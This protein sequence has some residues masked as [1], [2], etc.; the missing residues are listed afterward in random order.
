MNRRAIALHGL[1]LFCLAIALPSCA[2]KKEVK[3]E[4]SREV[5]V[6]KP[7]IRDISVAPSGRLDTSA[8]ERVV[9][10]KMT[11]DDNLQATFDVDGRFS[12]RT[13]Q[14][15]QPGE[16][17]GTFDVKQGETGWVSVTGHLL[18][19][20][21]GAHQD[22]RRERVLEL[23]APPPPPPSVCDAETAARYDIDLSALPILFHFNEFHVTD[24]ARTLLTNVVNVLTSHPECR[25]QVHGHTDRVGGDEYN[26]DLS[27][28]R[29]V[30][31]STFL[32]SLGIPSSR[33]EVIPHGKSMPLDT[34]GTPEGE[35]KNRRVEL[36]TQAGS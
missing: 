24:E 25:I 10:V 1:A 31:V 4:V 23:I 30:E 2:A 8:G 11:G 29:A 15:S 26:M 9:S 17:V 7:V 33:L 21:T 18:H 14:E 3:L 27:R 16:Y 34:S 6:A 35:M 19:A 5:V 36:H 32:E 28:K 20:P 12:G 22:S 13:M